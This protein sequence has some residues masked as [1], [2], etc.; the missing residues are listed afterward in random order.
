M[1]SDGKYRSRRAFHELMNWTE[2]YSVMNDV[3][4][5]ERVKE[6]NI[7]VVAKH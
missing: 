6:E 1:Y 4:K 2:R 5:K 7:T 3:A